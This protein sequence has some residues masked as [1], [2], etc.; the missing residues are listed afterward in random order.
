MINGQ[1]VGENG[2]EMVVIYFKVLFQHLSGVAEGN[3]ENPQ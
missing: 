2:K 1:E 3:D